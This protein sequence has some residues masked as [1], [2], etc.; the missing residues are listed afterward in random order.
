MNTTRRISCS[1]NF[2]NRHNMAATFATWMGWAANARACFE[3]AIK[4]ELLDR[5]AEAV[6]ISV[7]NL[8]FLQGPTFQKVDRVTRTIFPYAAMFYQP[9]VKRQIL[10]TTLQAAR[11]VAAERLASAAEI[12]QRKMKNL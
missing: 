6:S 8:L 1:E 4:I 2:F 11:P 7:P 5:I 12:P 9:G 10:S 3:S